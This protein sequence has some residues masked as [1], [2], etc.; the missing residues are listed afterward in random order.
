MLNDG[1]WQM[2][3][4]ELAK[5]DVCGA[6]GPMLRQYFYYDVHCDCC[7]GEQHFEY[8]YHCDGCVPRAP[9]KVGIVL[10]PVVAVER[11]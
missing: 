10:N 4:Q 8:E 7:G 2:S 11:K 3:E 9:T 1:R 6:E 5:C